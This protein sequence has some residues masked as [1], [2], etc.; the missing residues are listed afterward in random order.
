M[1]KELFA[2]ATVATLAI[3]QTRSG[4]QPE[5]GESVKHNAEILKQYSYKRRVE[6][7]V[8]GRSAE[9]VELVRYV[10]GKMET[11]PLETPQHQ[12]QQPRG[13]GLRGMLVRH[14]VAKKKEEMKEEVTRLIGLLHQYSP[15]SDAMRAALHDAVVSRVGPG[16]DTDI[17]LKTTG[18]VNPHDSLTLL[19]S[20]TDRRPNRIEIHTELDKKPVELTIQYAALADGPFY[21]ARTILSMPSKDLMLT[22][23]R[24]EY[25]RATAANKQFR[26]VYG[27][28]AR[29]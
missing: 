28:K 6:V 8:R 21:Q 29:V 12:A 25:S 7:S 5:F 19:W 1:K 23:E 10:N 15:E 13:R 24:F 18:V 26:S 16:R 20:V 27:T 3:A 17:S 11:V 22:I 4:K 2:L 9:R 14:E